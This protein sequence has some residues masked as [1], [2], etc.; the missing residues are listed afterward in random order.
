MFPCVMTVVMMMGSG[1]NL[2]TLRGQENVK[3]TRGQRQ[4]QEMKV[5]LVNDFNWLLPRK[6]GADILT[7]R[8]PNCRLLLLEPTGPSNMSV[9]GVYGA[10]DLHHQGP[11][12]MPNLVF[13]AWQMEFR[14]DSGC[15]LQLWRTMIDM[16]HRARP[17]RRKLE[18]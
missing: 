13:R 2:N 14:M 5:N 12:L 3:R 10:V 17:G 1:G 11:D 9:D 4:R 18:N 8:L 6:T 16:I 15:N 7:Q